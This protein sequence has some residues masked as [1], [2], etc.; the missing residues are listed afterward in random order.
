MAPLVLTDE[1]VE[2]IG[3]L[4][5]RALEL[6]DDLPPDQQAAVKA[7]VI[8]E[9]DYADI[10]KDMRCSEAVVRKRVSRALGNLRTQL[11]EK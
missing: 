4:D 11:E 9:R 8:D 2:R 7:R 5:H 1:L 3:E 10:A 6:V